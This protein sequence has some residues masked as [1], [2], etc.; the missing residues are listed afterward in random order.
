MF[1]LHSLHLLDLLQIKSVL[2]AR[3]PA[4]EKIRKKVKKVSDGGYLCTR[5]TGSCME[6]TEARS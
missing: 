3:R 4:A 6:L 5:Y 2:S 1:H